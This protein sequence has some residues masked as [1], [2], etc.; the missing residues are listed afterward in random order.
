[1]P[2]ATAACRAR[3]LAAG[4]S[5]LAGPD[6]AKAVRLGAGLWLRAA[7]ALIVL[8]VAGDWLEARW[9]AAVLNRAPAGVSALL[10]VGDLAA[11]ADSDLR[12]ELGLRSGAMVH[13]PARKISMGALHQRRQWLDEL[14]A[15]GRG[16]EDSHDRDS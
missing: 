7:A 16:M 3:A 4:R 9:T 5:A 2:P 1:M 11:A 13:T 15:E 8:S 6:A 14:G 10:P 12:R